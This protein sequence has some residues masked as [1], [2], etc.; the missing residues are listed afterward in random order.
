[1]KKQSLH[2][3]SVKFWFHITI[4]CQPQM[5][6]PQNGVIRG[7]PPPPPA[8]PLEVTLLSNIL[9]QKSRPVRRTI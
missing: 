4:W 9:I 5:V 7:E 6:S 3:K 1:M 8:T 2:H